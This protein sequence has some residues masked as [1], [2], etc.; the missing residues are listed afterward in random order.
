M[1]LNPRNRDTIAQ[2]P[3][4]TRAA[5]L[6]ALPQPGTPFERAVKAILDARTSG[7]NPYDRWMTARALEE[8]GL[9]GKGL[10]ES[11]SP[12][13]LLGI[14]VMVSRGRFVPVSLSALATSLQEF[15][16]ASSELDAEAL[17]A[18]RRRIAQIPAGLSQGD[19][20]TALNQLTQQLEEQWRAEIAAALEGA[21]LE[22]ID[23]ALRIAKESAELVE[24][25]NP[26]VYSF[27]SATVW[28]VDH[29][30][31]RYPSI[32]VLNASDEKVEPHI[33]YTDANE[34]VVTH[35]RATAGKVL[36]T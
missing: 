14:P 25:A 17:V 18:L 33:D 22:K 24:R 28:T 13:D 27:A 16:T 9:S 7:P 5:I 19:M 32:V 35:G 34:I 8:L 11:T 1:S 3:H 12:R 21:G 26:T 20:D 15:L 36:L 10:V 6:P 29:G 23:E 4:A 2:T 31:N 30:L